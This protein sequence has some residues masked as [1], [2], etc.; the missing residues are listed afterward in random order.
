MGVNQPEHVLSQVLLSLLCA[1]FTVASFA[2][3]K[4]QR[5][6]KGLSGPHPEFATVRN[7]SVEMPALPPG[8]YPVACSNLAHNV[9]RMNQLGGSLDDYWTGANDHYIATF[10]W[11]PPAP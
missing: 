2:T 6:E 1:C 9:G 3:M 5:I 11:N 7:H 10:C 4:N 8:E